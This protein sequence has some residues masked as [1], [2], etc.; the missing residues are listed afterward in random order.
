LLH[1]FVFRVWMCF[2]DVFVMF[3]YFCNFVFFKLVNLV[4][5]NLFDISMQKYLFE[6]I[7]IQ[8]SKLKLAAIRFKHANKCRQRG[9]KKSRQNIKQHTSNTQTAYVHWNR[10]I[11][12]HRPQ[13]ENNK[14]EQ[15]FQQFRTWIH[16]SF[17]YLCQ[18]NHSNHQTYT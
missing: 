9:S 10:Q 16:Y 17:E 8:W 6:Q 14:I 1:L 7:S 13:N 11:Q 18:F 12:T 5:R 4:A 15:I 2:D 3:W